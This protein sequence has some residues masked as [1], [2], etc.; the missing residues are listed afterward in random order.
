M[1]THLAW[2][3]AVTASGRLAALEQDSDLEVV[4]SVVLL[5][6]TR[7]GERRMDPDYGLLDML[8]PGADPPAIAAAIEEFEPRA[9]PALI[10][11]LTPRA[12]EEHAVVH[13]APTTVAEDAEETL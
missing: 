13:P 9:D 3:I 1:A 12:A 5:L 7:P 10:E 6:D 4:Q 11:Q 2:P 8:G